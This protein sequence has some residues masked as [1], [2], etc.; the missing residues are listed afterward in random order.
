MEQGLCKEIGGAHSDRPELVPPP[1]RE[2]FVV[3]LW[4]LP[5]GYKDNFICALVLIMTLA[6]QIRLQNTWF[7]EG[8]LVFPGIVTY[9]ALRLWFLARRYPSP[10]EIVIDADRVTLPPSITGDKKEVIIFADCSQ[11]NAVYFKTRGGSENVTCIEFAVSLQ[12]WR[13]NWLAADLNKFERVLVRR[14]VRV[15]RVR[16]R[17]EDMMNRGTLIIMLSLL[18]YLVVFFLLPGLVH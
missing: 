12:T 7:G 5:L 17:Y 15:A 1:P 18:L 9:L 6:L 14:G 11:V 3:R 8:W 10:G 13:V 2:T 4:G 16:G